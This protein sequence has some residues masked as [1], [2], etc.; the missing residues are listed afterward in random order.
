MPEQILRLWARELTNTGASS[1]TGIGLPNR[2]SVALTWALPYRTW[3]TEFH[4]VCGMTI[5][6]HIW[7]SFAAKVAELGSG[8]VFAW[9]VEQ[10]G[11]GPWM[12]KRR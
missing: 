2:G 12:E 10:I 6:G 11:D 5:A 3:R 4:V 9:I 1:S 7:G 8:H